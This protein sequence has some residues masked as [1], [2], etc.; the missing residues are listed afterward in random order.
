MN[1]NINMGVVWEIV[2]IK[3]N[4]I[5]IIKIKKISAKIFVK[6]NQKFNTFEEKIVYE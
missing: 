2:N 3:F 6:K 1:L 5:F 4:I